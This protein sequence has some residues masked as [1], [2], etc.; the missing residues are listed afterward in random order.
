MFH[1]NAAQTGVPIEDA[2]KDHGRQ[3]E[4]S[5]VL[6]RDEADG[7]RGSISPELNL[8]LAVIHKTWRHGI[9]VTVH[10]NVD[11]ERVVER[12]KARPDRIEVRVSERTRLRVGFVGVDHETEASIRDAFIHDRACQLRSKAQR[13]VTDRTQSVVMG[14]EVR[15]PSIK[16]PRTRGHDFG[17]FN[18]RDLVKRE[19]W[20]YPLLHESHE[21]E[22]VR[23]L[24]WIEGAEP[25]PAVPAC[26]H[27][28][29]FEL[30]HRGGVVLALFV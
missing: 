21:V 25:A 23:P 30:C 2:I 6:D 9:V 19:S 1:G 22:G 18:V 8:L 5:T 24:R 13:Q 4:F 17:V 29:G 3:K 20:Q 10:G 15:E 14:A 16:S 27:Q 12:F 7:G 26:V 11:H 28:I